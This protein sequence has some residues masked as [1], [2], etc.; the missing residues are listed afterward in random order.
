M[1][2]F[3]SAFYLLVIIGVPISI[4]QCDS[5]GISTVSIGLE[6]FCSCSTIETTSCCSESNSNECKIKTEKTSCCSNES[7]AIQWY[8]DHQIYIPQSVDNEAKELVL[9]S[10][11]S[12]NEELLNESAEVNTHY[13]FESPPSKIISIYLLKNEWIYYG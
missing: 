7:K 4:H 10:S 3:L 12:C 1:A 9:I 8:S 11:L 5:Q 2:I 6:E 13:S